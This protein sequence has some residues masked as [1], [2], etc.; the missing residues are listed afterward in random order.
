MYERDVKYINDKQ[1]L[2]WDSGTGFL[3]NPIPTGA[4]IEGNAFDVRNFR[5]GVLTVEGTG[6][7]LV[8]GSAQKN[9]PDFN[10]PSTI[11]NSWVLIAL[12]DYSLTGAPAFY[13]GAT[14]AVVSGSTMVCELDT[15]GL[16]WIGLYRSAEEVEAKLT[17]FTTQ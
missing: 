13:D 17:I 14:G 1:D 12:V 15:N 11:D 3:Q 16:T 4:L 10:S 9:Q 2:P 8:Y 6:Q 7:I 5:D